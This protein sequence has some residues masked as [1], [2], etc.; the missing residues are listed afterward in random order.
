MP[1]ITYLLCSWFEPR[2]CQDRATHYHHAYGL[3][4]GYH[5]RL[6]EERHPQKSERCRKLKGPL[7]KKLA[8]T[9]WTGGRKNAQGVVGAQV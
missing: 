1:R 6:I 3:V 4:C 9:E 5:A 7:L 8:I 2:I